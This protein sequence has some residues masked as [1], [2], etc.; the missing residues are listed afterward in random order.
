MDLFDEDL[1][2]IM[3]DRYDDGDTP[4][5][6][7]VMEHKRPAPEADKPAPKKNEAVDTQY[8]P[9]PKK[10]RN[11]MD[12]LR[13]VCAWLAVCGGVSM[14]MWWFWMNDMMVANAAYFCIWLS[15]IVGAFG[16]AWSV[17]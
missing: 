15:S 11:T 13:S 9:Y 3:G 10:K 14:L 8:V 2:E 16:V 17:K 12:K 4:T 7:P 6:M 1:K 5:E